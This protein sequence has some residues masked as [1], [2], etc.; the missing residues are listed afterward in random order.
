MGDQT[1]ILGDLLVLL[2]RANEDPEMLISSYQKD[3]LNR[4]F[5]RILCVCCPRKLRRKYQ[6][7]LRSK[8][9]QESKV[10]AGAPT[11]RFSYRLFGGVFLIKDC[12]IKSERRISLSLF[13]ALINHGAGAHAIIGHVNCTIYTS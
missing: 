3:Y 9:S 2:T 4:A 5:L 10:E 8:Q 12:V 1:R 7:Q 6:P 13:R 11:P